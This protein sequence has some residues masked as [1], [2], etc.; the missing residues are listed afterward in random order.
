MYEND[1]STCIHLV[2]ETINRTLRQR[3]RGCMFANF[4]GRFR[5]GGRP[6]VGQLEIR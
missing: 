1:N 3:E 2:L 4:G 5:K 6:D